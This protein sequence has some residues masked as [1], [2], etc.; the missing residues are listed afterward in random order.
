MNFKGK[1]FLKL[2]DFTPDE[3]GALLDLAEAFGEAYQTEKLRMNA[4]DF[5]AVPLEIFST[6]HIIP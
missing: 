6:R 5:S 4:A 2:L 1:H 3:I